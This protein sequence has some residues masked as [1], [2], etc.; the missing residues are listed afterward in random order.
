MLVVTEARF[1]VLVN[2]GF[3]LHAHNGLPIDKSKLWCAT[4]GCAAQH[5]LSMLVVSDLKART[6][7]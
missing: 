2:D 3:G 4:R 7:N 1:G 5:R 6:F